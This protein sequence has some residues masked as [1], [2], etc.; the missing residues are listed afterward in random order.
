MVTRGRPAAR[1][2][3]LPMPTR[4][5]MSNPLKALIQLKLE[6]DQGQKIFYQ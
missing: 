1:R 6:S 3:P 4:V 2:V 5:V